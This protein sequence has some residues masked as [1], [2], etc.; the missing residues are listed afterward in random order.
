MTIFIPFSEFA[1]ELFHLQ[2]TGS[3]V[4]KLFGVGAVGAFDGVELAGRDGST[5]I[6]RPSCWGRSDRTRR[7]NSSAVVFLKRSE[8]PAAGCCMP[9]WRRRQNRS[10]VGSRV[11]GSTVLKSDEIRSFLVDPF[12]GP[13]PSPIA[14]R[15]PYARSRF[16]LA[17]SAEPRE[18][19]RLWNHQVSRERRRSDFSS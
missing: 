13:W 2:R 10:R 18:F 7:R 16:V 4:P 17:A 9:R 12:V 15:R 1:I 5:N 8:L 19:Y 14:R 6:R 11:L 3:N